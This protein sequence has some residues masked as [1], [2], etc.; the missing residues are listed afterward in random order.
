MADIDDKFIDVDFTQCPEYTFGDLGGAF[1]SEMP[2][3]EEQ[4]P[5][6]PESRWQEYCE[7]LEATGG[8]LDA[9]V[10]RIYNQG[11]EGSCVANACSQAHEIKQ[12]EML[13]KDKV[14]H[15][16]AISLY[17]RIGRSP[18]SGAM[19]SDGLDEGSTRGILPL[20]NP[21]NRAKWGNIVMPATGFYEKFPTGWE[22][23]GK[24]FRFDERFIIRSTEG[25]ISALLNGHP[26]VVGREGHSICYCRPMW[27]SGR[28]VVK[29]AN[30]WG[31][32]G[33]QGY[34]YDS[35]NQIRKSASWAFAV[36]SV[37]V[38]GAIL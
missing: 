13:G 38:P 6:V 20:D 30:S 35:L 23:V 25:I 28:L 37:I 17:K 4:L 33:D 22:Q 11:R 15:L 2:C 31:S 16:S 14:V 18:G 5:I 32:W 26:V 3:Y 1:C 24:L 36:R 8:G 21:E 7:K 19:V 10:T 9:L 29:Y 27:R 34:G 12:A